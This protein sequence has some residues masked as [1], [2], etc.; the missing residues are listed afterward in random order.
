[1]LSNNGSDGERRR[2]NY[3]VIEKHDRIHH[4]DRLRTTLNDHTCFEKLRRA[5]LT[6]AQQ[7]RLFS[8]IEAIFKRAIH[9]R[10]PKNR[11]P[12]KAG[13]RAEKGYYR[14]LYLEGELH[15]KVDYRDQTDRDAPAYDWDHMIVILGRLAD[16]PD[17][18]A[19]ILQR[20]ESALDEMAAWPPA[21]D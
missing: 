15:T 2:E 14:L 17:L 13:L 8:M 12:G 6:H 18:Q 10:S 20:V 9:A 21:F 19:E 11:P 4:H 3:P 16:I 5:A 7:Q 1:M